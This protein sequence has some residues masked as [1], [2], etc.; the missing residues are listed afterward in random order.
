[1]KAS[2]SQ[3]V[4]TGI[5]AMVG[6]CLLI[7]AIF[8]IG[9]TKNLF[10]STFH[11]Y[12]TFKNVGGLQVGNNVRFVGINVGTVQSISIVSDT[13]ARVDMV[14][15]KKVNQFIK[16]TAVA[17]IGSDGL[18]GDKL[19]VISATSD[20]GEMVNSGDRIATEN[21][22]DFSKTMAK[23]N[24]IADNAEVITEALANIATNISEGK[25]S[26]GRLLYN[27]KLAKNLESTTASI[28]EGTEGF[29]D[30]MKALKSNFL[31]RGYYK[32]KEKEE[33]EKAEQNSSGKTDAGEEPA[34]PSRAE[35]RKQRKAEKAEKKEEKTG[36]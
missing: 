19:I 35:R 34:K 4:R 29:S 8:L 18:M 15:E 13:L 5:F 1:M 26:L 22:A 36:Q 23:V 25:G 33:K 7:G 14:I 11:I 30:N 24:K 9:K 16:K 17:S 28:K 2:N 12:G 31:L 27:D 32:K 6:L 3:K 10:G 21:P 20:S